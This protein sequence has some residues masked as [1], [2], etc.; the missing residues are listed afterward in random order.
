[1]AATPTESATKKR[2]QDGAREDSE[3]ED[4][5]LHVVLD[6][7]SVDLAQL[8][9]RSVIELSIPL[10]DTTLQETKIGPRQ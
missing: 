1:M 2:D 9:H 5:A 7:S 10:S 3:R 4:P 6:N 8:K